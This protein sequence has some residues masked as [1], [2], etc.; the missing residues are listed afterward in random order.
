MH[1][2]QGDEVIRIKL[3]GDRTADFSR[4]R[5]ELGISRADETVNGVSY[6]WH[7]MDDFEI[8]SGEAYGTMQLVKSSAH[9]GTGVTGMQHSGSVSQ[10]KAYFGSGY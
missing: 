9:Q 6:T 4:A 3:S 10:W 7:H 5:T 2:L 1:P 8:I